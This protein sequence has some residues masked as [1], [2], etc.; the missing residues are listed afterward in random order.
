M[1]Y[2]WLLTVLLIAGCKDSDH[3]GV[4][5]GKDC[6][7]DDPRANPDAV[8]VCDGIDN[9]CDGQIDEDVSI[10]AYLDQDRDGYGDEASRRRVCEV[11]ENG[12]TEAGDCDDAYLCNDTGA[13]ETCNEIDD[14][15]DG[16]IDEDV[17]RTY[18]ADADE[19]GHGDP[20]DT[21]D[22]C[23]TPDGYAIAGDDCDDA[24]PAAWDGAAEIC[25]GVDNDCDG[26]TDEDLAVTRQWADLDGDGF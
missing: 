4:R 19:D 11:P 2:G 20:T 21:L 16:Q 7:P 17:T 3:D 23:F 22:A 6:L 15:C 1:R 24:E 13:T 25:D 26:T 12:S 18:Y 8:E 14:D 10:V 5:D 9:D